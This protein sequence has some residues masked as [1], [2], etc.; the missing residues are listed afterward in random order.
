MARERKTDA[1]LGFEATLWQARPRRS[2]RTRRSGID[3][4]RDGRYGVCS[5]CSPL[6]QPRGPR[7]GFVFLGNRDAA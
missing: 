3:T 4:L 1:N 7:R 5:I 2:P 6:D